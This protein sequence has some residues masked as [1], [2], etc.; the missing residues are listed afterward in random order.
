MPELPEAFV[1]DDEDEIDLTPKP[2]DFDQ[3]GDR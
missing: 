3:D 1:V 2:L